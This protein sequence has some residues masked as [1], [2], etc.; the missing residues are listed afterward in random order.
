MY[1]SGGHLP[2]RPVFHQLNWGPAAAFRSAT[3]RFDGRIGQSGGGKMIRGG[4]ANIP[5]H[6]WS[7][8]IPPRPRIFSYN[9]ERIAAAEGIGAWGR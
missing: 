9:S 2:L 3:V 7:W 8:Q 1:G 4:M 5:L 6:K